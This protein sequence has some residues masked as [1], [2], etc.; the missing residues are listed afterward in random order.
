MAVALV[1]RLLQEGDTLVLKMPASGSG[2]WPAVDRRFL[3]T[4]ARGGRGTDRRLAATPTTDLWAR[5]PV[6]RSAIG[7][8]KHLNTTPP[9][10][11]NRPRLPTGRPGGSTT[12]NVPHRRQT[13]AA[14]GRRRSSQRHDIH[15]MAPTGQHLKNVLTSAHV[16]T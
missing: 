15:G 13:S 6:T 9:T 12:A 10:A 14:N 16:P 2:R 1:Q 8:D 3:G 7:I 5:W 11:R 4:G